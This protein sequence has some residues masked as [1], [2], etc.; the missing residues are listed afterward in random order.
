MIKSSFVVVATRNGDWKKVT[1]RWS[2]VDTCRILRTLCPLTSRR[3]ELIPFD[4]ISI[5]LLDGVIT[6]YLGNL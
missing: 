6:S 5:R 4:W 3:K 1:T 2:A